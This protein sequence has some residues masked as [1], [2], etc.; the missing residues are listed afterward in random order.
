[1]VETKYDKYFISEIR[2]P[3][4]H[5][6][7][8]QPGDWRT[9][10]LYLDNRVLEGAFYLSSSWWHNKGEINKTNAVQRHTHDFDE[11][12]AFIG[13]NPSD[14]TDLGGEI[15]LWMDDE[16]HIISKSCL[17]FVPKGVPHCPMFPIRIDRPILHFTTGPSVTY[18]KFGADKK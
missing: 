10:I 13:N 18:N 6:N 12:I 14:P 2:Y 15:E 9:R 1:M 8:H 11:V 5:Q 17:V 4:P 3:D 16:K 7:P